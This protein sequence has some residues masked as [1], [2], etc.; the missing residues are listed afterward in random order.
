ML[1]YF[2]LRSICLFNWYDCFLTSL[3]AAFTRGGS[4]PYSTQ[5]VVKNNTY[6]E[7]KGGPWAK[8]LFKH[9]EA[10]AWGRYN[11]NTGLQSCWRWTESFF[12]LS[13]R[14]CNSLHFSSTSMKSSS[15]NFILIHSWNSSLVIS[16]SLSSIITV[17]K[18]YH[19]KSCFKLISTVGCSCLVNIKRNLYLL[20]LIKCQR[21]MEIL[22]KS[23]SIS[24]T[25]H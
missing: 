23:I 17:A 19:F 9:P 11:I 24:F 22:F 15:F 21:Y 3:I 6:K 16:I 5:A 12:L 1:L 8:S 4:R 7:P 14:D 2:L 25:I 20:L 18:R 13:K 10:K